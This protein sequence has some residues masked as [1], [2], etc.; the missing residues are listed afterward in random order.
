[1]TEIPESLLQEQ[2]MQLTFAT[3]SVT[4]IEQMNAYHCRQSDL[5]LCTPVPFAFWGLSHPFSTN[6]LLRRQGLFHKDPLK[7]SHLSA[8]QS[9]PRRAPFTFQEICLKPGMAAHVESITFPRTHGYCR[10]PLDP[11]TRG[12][13]TYIPLQRMTIELVQLQILSSE[14]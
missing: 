11:H 5:F 12:T 9:I 7:S 3:V 8:T 2:A 14:D 4:L 10:Q 6:S 1:M 13:T